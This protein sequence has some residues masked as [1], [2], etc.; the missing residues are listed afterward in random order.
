MEEECA[1]KRWSR[2]LVDPINMEEFRKGV[3]N[4]EN[5]KAAGRDVV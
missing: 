1:Q 4:D 2:G 5:R 3:N